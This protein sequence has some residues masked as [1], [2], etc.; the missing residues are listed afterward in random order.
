[1]IRNLNG[2]S[3]QVLNFTCVVSLLGTISCAR[4]M[5]KTADA[6]KN[7]TSVEIAAVSV[8]AAPSLEV[9]AKES[10]IPAKS[11]NIVLS[12]EAAKIATDLKDDHRIMGSAK[13]ETPAGHETKT[14]FLYGAEHLKLENY[15]FDIPVVYNKAVK[16]WISYFLKRGRGFFE[17]YSARAGVY[18]PV[19][20]KILA[21]YGMPRDLIF[22]AMAESGFQTGAKSWAK[23]V[24]PWQFMHYTGKRFGLKIDWYRD[25][26]R[27]PIKATIAAA[28]YLRKLYG[29]FGSWELAAAAYNA[30]EGKI[31]R[32]IRRYNTESFWDLRKGRYLKAETKNYVPKIMALAI[33]GKNLKAFGFEDI[34]FHEPLDFEE[35]DLGPMTDLFKIA[36]ALDVDF[37]EIQRLNPEILRW[38]TPPN[39][40]TYKLRIPVG[41]SVAWRKCCF[42]HHY[43][44]T[45]FQEYKVR[46]KRTTLSDVSRK[47]KIKDKKVLAKLSNISHSSWLKKN[48]TIILPFKLGQSKKARMYAD[49]YEKPRR[50]VLRRRKYRRLIKTAKRKGR[51]ITSPSIYYTVKKGDSLWSVS[52]KSGT[53]L[54]T[55]IASNMR[56]VKRRQIRAGDRLVV[57]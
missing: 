11:K 39:I 28:K 3:R 34:D 51:R 33:I 14:F 5:K 1:M 12:N 21:D 19:L 53:S 4:F 7:P 17:R 13:I 36:E 22:L 37:T 32:A 24:G 49:L 40:E 35:I 54:Y 41:K 55:I 38:F 10:V 20:G 48:T 6:E 2:L 16:N 42:D 56:I 9:T 47:F 43:V 44:A 31:G 52:R 15:Y 57:K 27:D 30:G 29:D 8:E 23:A 25:E 50:S 26:R 45:E 46:G 18:A